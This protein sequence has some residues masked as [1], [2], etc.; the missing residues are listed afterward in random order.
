M[1]SK[2]KNFFYIWKWLFVR[3]WYKSY[4]EMDMNELK[5]TGKKIIRESERV[6]LLTLGQIEGLLYLWK[7]FR[8]RKWFKASD[9]IRE[10]LKPIGYTW[11]EPKKWQ[12]DNLLGHTIA[13]LD[14]KINGQDAIIEGFVNFKRTHAW[15]KI[16][17]STLQSS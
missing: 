10:R 1:I 15:H 14:F 12:A 8:G 16:Y 4:T 2:I 9:L 6:S 11:K 13:G 5:Q 7:F 3:K 17:Y